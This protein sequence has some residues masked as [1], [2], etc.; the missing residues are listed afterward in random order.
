VLPSRLILFDL[1]L[2]QALYAPMK[3]KKMEFFLK[4]EVFKW[5]PFLVHFKWDSIFKYWI[6]TSGYKAYVLE[7]SLK[8]VK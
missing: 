1:T 3:N 6:C 5:H 4:K 2:T 7:E 8:C